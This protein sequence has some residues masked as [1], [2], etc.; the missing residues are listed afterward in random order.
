MAA[1]RQIARAGDRPLPAKVPPARVLGSREPAGDSGGG[2][3]DLAR[4]AVLF[5]A[6]FLVLWVSY[7]L[8]LR[9]RRAV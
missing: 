6:T 5:G 2:S 7:E 1:V 8:W 9:R 4:V 3:T